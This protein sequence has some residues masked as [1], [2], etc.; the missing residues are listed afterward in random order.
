MFVG[1]SFDNI[2]QYIVSVRLVVEIKINA[3]TN[4][5]KNIFGGTNVTNFI[6]P[7]DSLQ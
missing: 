2:E 5:Y 4:Y 6:G 7:D 1:L 3:R